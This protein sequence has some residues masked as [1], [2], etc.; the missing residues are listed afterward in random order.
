STQGG[1]VMGRKPDGEP[2]TTGNG[3]D[4][5]VGGHTACPT[6]KALPLSYGLFCYLIFI[7]TLLYAIGFVGNLVVPFPC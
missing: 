6:T 2:A 5:T 1:L 7:C 3:S 4:C